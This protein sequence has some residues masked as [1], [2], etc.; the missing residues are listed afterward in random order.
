MLPKNQKVQLVEIADQIQ[1]LH[2]IQSLVE[3]S[4]DAIHDYQ[5]TEDQRLNRIDLLL[6]CYRERLRQSLATMTEAITQART[7]NP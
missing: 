5:L 2:H 6:T 7:G 3:L 4:I 1:N